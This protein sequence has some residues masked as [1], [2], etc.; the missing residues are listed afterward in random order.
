MRDC[1][2]G[3]R[4]VKFWIMVLSCGVI[5]TLRQHQDPPVPFGLFSHGRDLLIET[6]GQG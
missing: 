1:H 6:Q 3:L 2:V 4:L 5:D